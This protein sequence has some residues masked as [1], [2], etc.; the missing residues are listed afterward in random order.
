MLSAVV[1]TVVELVLFSRTF[2]T[3]PAGLSLAHV[4]VGGLSEQSAL[5]QLLLVYRAP[6]ELRYQDQTILL[7]PAAVNFQVDTTL[8][9]P[10]VNQYRGNDSFWT[11][12]WD[13]LWLQ[14]GQTNDV[15]L[16]ATYSRERLQ[17]FLEDVAARYDRPGSPP[18]ANP[19]KLGF[20]PGEPGHSLDVAAAFSLVDARLRSPSD[21]TV[22][23]PVTEQTAI[24]PGFDTLSELIR[25]DVSL[26]QF[27]GVVSLYLADLSTGRELELSLVNQQ[28]TEGRIAFSGMSTI[29][30]AIMVSF[31][32]HNDGALT[33]EQ[34][35]LLKRSIDESQNTATDL[36]LKTIGRGDGFEGTRIVT[37]DM[38]RLGLPNTYISGLLDTLG[39]V[40]APLGTP[41]NA[42]TDI[43]TQPDPYNQTTAED[44]GTLLVMIDQC[45]QGGGALFAAFPG[46]FTADECRQMIDLLT[47]NLVGPIFI[48]GGSSPGGVVA[49]KHG[50]D[51]LP[52]NNVAD[53]AIVFTPGGTYVLTVYIH[54]DD[55]MTFDEANRMLISVARAIY[56]FF[57][58]QTG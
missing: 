51:R 38:Q 39:A 18:K 22:N 30:I 1:L 10:Q 35:L 5:E 6:L 31:F 12:F 48:T 17:A 2:A 24:R 8:M 9:L 11:G 14:P 53:A 32:A 47:G 43:N 45:S 40:L 25:Q 19:D 36:L 46:Q 15:P 54:R 58:G 37:A 56:N 57:N 34:N 29:K 44:M 16:Q 42:R 13:F 33:N 41:A 49:H 7:E 28:P 50:W 52:L 3:L 20:V 26:F 55:T 27:Q 23:L 4:P 21:R